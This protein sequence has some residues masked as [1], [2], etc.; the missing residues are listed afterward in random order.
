MPLIIPFSPPLSIFICVKRSQLKTLVKE[1][2]Q[3]VNEQMSPKFWWMSPEAK[4][5]RVAPYEHYPWAQ[6]YLMTHEGYPPEEVEKD[7][8]ALMAQ[9]GW[10]RVP[11]FDYMGKKTIEYDFSKYRPLTQ[12]QMKEL[13]DMAVEEG[14]EELIPH[15]YD[16]K[17]V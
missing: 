4:L 17:P 14:V 2:V 5:H 7:V 3:M 15:A 9:L 11:L 12:R 10:V 6:K 13:K 1:I 8:Y 16:I